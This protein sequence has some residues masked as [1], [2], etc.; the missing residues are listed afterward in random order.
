MNKI[1]RVA[2]A[3]RSF[4]KNE[5]L[6]GELLK[7]YEKVTFNDAGAKLEGDSLYGF[8]KGHN[9]AITA[10][11]RID[12]SL[13]SKLPELKVIGKYGVG[14]DMLD[15]E[16]MHQ[17]GVKLGWTGGV[18]KR[19]V[20][21]LVIAFMIS[22]LR[23]VPKA[24]IEVRN[25]VWQQH[26]GNYLSGKTIGII[27][28]GNVGKDLVYILQPFNC[29]I[30]VNDILDYKQFY[31]QYNIQP[32]GLEELLMKSDVVTLHVPLDKSTYNILNAERIVQMKQ[33]A[34]LINAARGGMVD[35]DALRIALENGNLAAAAFDV[36]SQ[37]PPNDQALLQ[38]PNFLSTP[39]IGGSAEESVLAMG[40][41]AI[42][43][44]DV[45]DD[46]K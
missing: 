34:V 28:C 44:L 21:E 19:S 26:I 24:N 4:S 35:E 20:S 40:M 13:L 5:T 41:A 30:L 38:L 33:S 46:S 22:L 2:V 27:G 11:E 9:K 15:Q 7:R 25:G 39:H 17:Y 6:R 43:G 1:D 23:H 29:P 42:N 45:N 32:L 37:E 31:Q 12:E 36:F 14:L 3:S 18:N 16:A 8:L 10:L